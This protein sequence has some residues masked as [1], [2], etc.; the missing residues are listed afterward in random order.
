[1]QYTM[2]LVDNVSA[3]KDAMAASD[4]NYQQTAAQT[5]NVINQESDAT[6]EAQM[7]QGE[8]SDSARDAGDEVRASSAAADEAA[9]SERRLD[10]AAKQTNNTL[11]ARQTNFLTQITMV[12][13]LH[14]SISLT[15]NAF[16]E[17]GIVNEAGIKMMRQFGAGIDLV[18]AAYQGYKGVTMIIEQLRK[19]EIGLAAVEA[20][21]A[22]LKNPLALGLVAA[23]VGA[24][25][26]YA[27][28]MMM[29]P[30]V[31]QSTNNE[32][33]I[34]FTAPVSSSDQRQASRGALENMGGF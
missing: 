16:Q 26:G 15:T 24:V 29:Q 11:Q 27:G 33:K 13:A 6:K 10:G 4:K 9:G 22:V 30:Q 28:A 31:Q 8:L 17:L 1:V 2:R 14:S 25:A 20:F 3:T 19:A 18:V 32:Y 23:G 34:Q 21:R 7:N 5:T 12:R